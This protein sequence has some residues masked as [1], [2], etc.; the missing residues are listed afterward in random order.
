[1]GARERDGMTMT[2]IMI[3][4]MSWV[5]SAPQH[6]PKGSHSKATHRWATRVINRTCRLDTADP[7]KN[8]GKGNDSNK[9]TSVPSIRHWGKGKAALQTPHPSF[10]LS[11]Q[12][13]VSL[14]SFEP[15]AYLRNTRLWLT[16]GQPIIHNMLVH[17]QKKISPGNAPQ[18]SSRPPTTTVDGGTAW[19]NFVP[20]SHH[21]SWLPLVSPRKCS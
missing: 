2:W 9:H 17:Q 8:G 6:H 21:P 1:M 7:A 4:L 13:T 5:G 18:A 15:S 12:L 10:D 16:V 19:A 20:A 3:M 11:V 14:G